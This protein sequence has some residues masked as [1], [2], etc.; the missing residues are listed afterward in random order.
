MYNKTIMK[1]ILLI[2][3]LLIT[4]AGSVFASDKAERKQAY[5][6]MINSQKFHNEVCQRA[7]DNFRVDHRLAGYIR[8]TCLMFQSERQRL[9]E[10][11][12]PSAN[13]VEDKNY[14]ED[15]PILL[16]N[17][18]ININNREID[19]YKAIITEYCKYNTYKYVK[20]DPQACSPERINAIFAPM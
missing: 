17:F 8:S 7:A 15:Y 18:I 19:T 1:K 11:V 6:A 14:K 2:T 16:S 5:N 4:F 10:T 20:K 9:I 12:F 13:N 3:F